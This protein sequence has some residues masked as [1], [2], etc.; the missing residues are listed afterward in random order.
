MN[1]QQEP[2]IVQNEQSNEEKDNSK[3]EEK[4]LKPVERRKS[5]VFEVAEKFN[6]ANEKPTKMGPPKKII[7]PG[8]NVE[9]ARKEFERRSSVTSGSSSPPKKSSTV[10]PTSPDEPFPLASTVALNKLVESA[11]RD[12]PGFE[13]NSPPQAEVEEM[14]LAA[15]VSVFVQ[16]DC[17]AS[18]TLSLSAFGEILERELLET[19]PCKCDFLLSCCELSIHPGMRIGKNYQKSEATVRRE[20]KPFESD[21]TDC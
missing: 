13:M 4:Q 9:G 1:T 14:K 16:G 15:K 8:S 11:F 6:A 10:T 17:N 5:K 2:T 20:T 7:L 3:L 19:R 12:E 18:C 21:I